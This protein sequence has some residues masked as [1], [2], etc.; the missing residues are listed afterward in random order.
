MDEPYSN[1]AS[2]L[3]ASLP[4]LTIGGLRSADQLVSQSPQSRPELNGT[5][6]P[7]KDQEADSAAIF[8]H[9]S[10]TEGI[11]NVTILV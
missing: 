10:G 5:F 11:E 2:Q 9:S 4:S 3:S 1:M 7:N 6:S 8:M